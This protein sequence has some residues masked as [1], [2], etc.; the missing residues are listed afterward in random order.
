MSYVNTFS[1]EE[2]TYLT[3]AIILAISGDDTL[4]TLGIQFRPFAI[5]VRDTK[6]HIQCTESLKSLFLGIFLCYEVRR[7]CWNLTRAFNFQDLK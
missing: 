6:N 4:G 3:N 5:S 1:L 2:V 7:Q